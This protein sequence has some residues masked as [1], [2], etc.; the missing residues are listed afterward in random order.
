M[1][2]SHYYIRI[3]RRCGEVFESESSNTQYC[4]DECRKKAIRISD[5]KKAAHK[6]ELALAAKNKK[7][8]RKWHAFSGPADYARIQ[9]EETVALFA[10]ID[11]DNLYR[12]VLQSA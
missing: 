1:V 11:L 4:C 8:V 7:S 2:K 9:K 5:Q 6:K 10:R 3:C 12:E